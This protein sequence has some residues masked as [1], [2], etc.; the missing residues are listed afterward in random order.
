MTQAEHERLAFLAELRA[1]TE[2]RREYVESLR[3]QVRAAAK[4]E[5]SKG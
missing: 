3:E 4:T 5:S 1:D 2:R